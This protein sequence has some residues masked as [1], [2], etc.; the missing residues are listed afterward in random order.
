MS[1]NSIK[2]NE[3][4]QTVSEQ[5]FKV[6]PMDGRRI[7]HDNVIDV[8]GLK[9][10]L[11]EFQDDEPLLG[12][13]SLAVELG[14]SLGSYDSFISDEASGRLV[15]DCLARINQQRSGVDA[16]IHHIASGRNVQEATWRNI[17]TYLSEHFEQT[18]KFY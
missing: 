8:A 17:E 11:G 14:S 12:L 2:M 13:A 18:T 3:F 10:K 15:T 1:A 16:N 9:H 7:Q 4:G 6:T 5:D